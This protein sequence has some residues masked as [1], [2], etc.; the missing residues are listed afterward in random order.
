MMATSFGNVP[1]FSDGNVCFYGK[2][3]YCKP[4]EA[5]CAEGDV[6]EGSLTLWIPDWYKL[7]TKRHPYQR[8]YRDGV[9]ARW[10]SDNT[11]CQRQLLKP[12]SEYYYGILEFTDTAVFDFLMGKVKYYCTCIGNLGIGYCVP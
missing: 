5:A 11:Y 1:F 6:M 4:S 12:A 8:T 10:E 7:T 3:Y 9:K 2:C